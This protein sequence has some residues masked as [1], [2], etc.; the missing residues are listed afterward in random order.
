MCAKFARG[1][2]EGYHD[3]VLIAD[4]LDIWLL[5][6]DIECGELDD[7]VFK[8]GYLTGFLDIYR[9]FWISRYMVFY[10][11]ISIDH[12]PVDSPIIPN[13]RY[14]IL[15]PHIHF[16]GHPSIS[17]PIIAYALHP[18]LLNAIAAGF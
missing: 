12:W 15:V 18:T 4:V 8:I 9:Y 11:Y 14:P 6:V 2:A 13:Y 10:R 1:Y 17:I 3:A 5:K 7:H 16:S